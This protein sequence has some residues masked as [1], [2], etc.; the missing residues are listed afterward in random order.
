MFF[1]KWKICDKFCMYIFTVSVTYCYSVCL[2]AEVLEHKPQLE[3]GKNPGY[4]RTK[5]TTAI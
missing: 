4:F 2:L 3:I 5:S 1:S